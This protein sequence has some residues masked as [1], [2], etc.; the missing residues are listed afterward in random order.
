MMLIAKSDRKN[1]NETIPDKP[2][3]RVVC[4]AIRNCKGE[5]IC[6]ARHYDHIMHSQIRISKHKRYWKCVWKI[7][8]FILKRYP[9]IEQGFIDQWDI[10]MTREEAFDVATIT[11]QRIRRC[12]GDSR[13]LFS[14]NLY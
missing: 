10:F 1:M 11:G 13:Q 5:I 6:G 4:A 12:G 2:Q 8:K 9:H 14:E 7:G 3:R